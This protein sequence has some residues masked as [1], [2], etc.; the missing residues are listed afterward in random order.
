MEMNFIILQNIILKNW[1]EKIEGG[2]NY[3]TPIQGFLPQVYTELI[4]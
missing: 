2:V 3:T 4:L 1:S